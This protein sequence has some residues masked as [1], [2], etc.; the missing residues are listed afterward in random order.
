MEKLLIKNVVVFNTSS[1]VEIKRGVDVLVSDGVIEKVGANVEP[2]GAAVLDGKGRI[3]IPGNVVGH[4]HY[5]SALSRG[6]IL[7]HTGSQKDFIGTLQNWWWKIDRALDE[8]ALYYSSLVASIESIKAGSTGVID[9]H[10]SP[11]FIS[12]SLEVI[13]KGMEDVGIRGVTCFEVTNRNGGDDEERS[14]VE[15][16]VAFASFVDEKRKENPRYLVESMIGA[17]APFTISDGALSLLKGAVEKTGRG[18]HIHVA[19]DSYDTSW[20]HHKYGKDITERLESF[21]LLDEKTLLVHGIA[22]Y[23]EEIERINSHSS[24]L[25]H[26]ARSNMNNQV[27]YA[28]LIKN[29][30]NLILGTD[31]CGGNMF[32]EIRIA[33]FKGRDA[34]LGWWPSDYLGA[35][36]K[37]SVF[38]SKCFGNRIALGRVDEGYRGDLVLLDYKSPTPLVEENAATHFVWGMDS[39]NVSSVIV[40]GKVLYDE[41]RFIGLDED[42]IYSKAR[43]E[44]RKVW[45]R[46]DSFK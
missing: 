37:G 20:S 36:A 16:N 46:A 7:P 19:E 44:A 43:E 45:S 39:S 17:H 32:E 9:H 22:L 28:S 15:E 33:F 41:K 2:E 42:E 12:G 24:Y 23:P 40:D 35:L 30:K 1:P 21:D 11:S 27:G 4:H 3:M 34:K 31:G 13:A 18:L 5:Y 38:L 26:N 14:G 29:V 10:A 8:K 6:M 25:A